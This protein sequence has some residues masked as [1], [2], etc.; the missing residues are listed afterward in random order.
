ME[1]V[2][3][4]AYSEPVRMES[5]QLDGL[6]SQL[7]VSGAEDVVC[8]AME[9]IALRMNKAVR[10]FGDG[11]L[12]DL[13]KNARSL[14]SIAD[15]IGLSGLSTTARDVTHCIDDGDHVALSAVLNR[16]LRVGERSLTAIWDLRDIS[17]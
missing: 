3:L 17:I 2:T 14:V 15:Q 4:L 13:R 5:E 12:E 11:E 6:Y 10:Q 7:G 1:R 9:E 8:R 16:F